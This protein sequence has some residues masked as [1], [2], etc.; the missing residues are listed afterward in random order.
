MVYDINMSFANNDSANTKTALLKLREL[1]D[2][3]MIYASFI[4]S[5][6]VKTLK[7]G[8]SFM[9]FATRNDLKFMRKNYSQELDEAMKHVFGVNS[10]FDLTCADDFSSLIKEV[11]SL[12]IRETNLNANYL[13]DN[14][15]E[16]KFNA[17][18]IALG[19]KILQQE[20]T[21][22]NPIFIYSASGLGKTHFLHA[23]GNALT[24]RK[25]VCY[26]NPDHFMKK[27]TQYLI[28]SNQ[29]KLGEIIDY[30][31]D[32]DVLLFDD[33]QL[34][35]SKPA[36]LNVLFNILN[37]HIDQQNQIVIAADKNPD[38]LGGFEERFITRFQGGITEEISNPSLEDLILIFKTKLIQNN[39]DPENWENEAVKF[40][41]RNH[42][43]SIRTL[44]GA[45]NKIE[46]NRQNSPQNVRYTY[47]VVSQMF[48]SITRETEN[49]TPERVVEIVTRFYGLTRSEILG[50][51]RR[52]EVV[53][54]RHISMWMIRNVLNLTYKDI[55]LF[56]KGKDHSTV[57]NAIDK[58]DYQMKVNETIKNAL[59]M[60]KSKLG[61]D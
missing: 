21:T 55:G 26:V 29:D 18:V 24:D 60:I 36:T 37:Y 51:S 11:G 30:Y 58:I 20:K 57:M 49:V 43:N 17:K 42:S 28:Q 15:V 47:Q 4:E 27:I 6:N 14:Y 10:H 48:S 40:I 5:I 33:I 54:A 44:E 59:K 19:K 9:I 35:G 46:W 39:Q 56:F 13:A 61:K 34:Y 1:I 45:I 32:F 50:K 16:A 7:N 53:L 12:N 41:V 22:F 52:K 23:V 25:N 31:K 8:E 2:D 38:L 3:E